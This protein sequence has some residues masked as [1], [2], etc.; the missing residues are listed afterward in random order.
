MGVL[1]SVPD[2]GAGRIVA[3]LYEM[4]NR[5]DD[6]W[7]DT[8][9]FMKMAWSWLILV[10]IFEHIVKSENVRSRND[11]SSEVLLARDTRPS[12]EALV[13][14]ACQGV[15]AVR[16]TVA[17]D[18]GILT[19]LQLHWMVQSFNNGVPAPESDFFQQLSNSFRMLVELWHANTGDSTH[20]EEL[21]VDAA[22]GV[23]ASKL[24][25]LQ[26]LT[27]SLGLQV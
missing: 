23:G 27:T 26:H 14:A 2:V 3:P 8:T 22:N 1:N 15:E 6:L 10:M 21:I 4:C 24:T 16:G 9:L 17:H 18:M 11:A 13:P 25:R 19:T 20:S 12:G 7:P 5:I